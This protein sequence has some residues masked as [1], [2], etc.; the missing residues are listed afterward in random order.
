MSIN[1]PD[2]SFDFKLLVLFYITLILKMAL[3]LFPISYKYRARLFGRHGKMND[4]NYASSI[5]YKHVSLIDT[6]ESDLSV[7]EI[8]PGDSCFTVYYAL[9]NNFKFCQLIDKDISSTIGSLSSLIN[10]NV[11]IER[12]SNLNFKLTLGNNSLILE[13]IEHSFDKPLMNDPHVFTHIFSNA[14]CQHMPVSQL[15]N[16]FNYIYI[17]SSI[18][19]EISHQIR[20]TD[21]IIGPLQGFYHKHVPS[22]IWN[23]NLLQSFPFW[24]NRLLFDEYSDLFFEYGFKL[25]NCGVADSSVH[26]FHFKLLKR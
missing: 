16:L 24:T 20:F 8:G 10:K 7:L 19:T 3:Y 6:P 25:N 12:L 2:N 22:F 23:T 13:L 1:S 4:F 11:L 15:K 14:V 21:H 5:F 26:N 17:C 9:I 18:H